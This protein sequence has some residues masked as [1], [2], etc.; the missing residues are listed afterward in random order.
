M[1]LKLL[2][3]H[4]SNFIFTENEAYFFSVT[5]I[6][7]RSNILPDRDNS[8][9][10]VI[11]RFDNIH[12]NIGGRYDNTTGEFTCKRAGVYSFTLTNTHMLDNVT[13][14]FLQ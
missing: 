11:V 4:L 3:L 14:L 1:F 10:D 5:N 8:A 12:L 9:G 13:D 2:F 7:D 6:P